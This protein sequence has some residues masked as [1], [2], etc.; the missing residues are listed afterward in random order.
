MGVNPKVDFVE[1]SN[2][3]R[4]PPKIQGIR[5]IVDTSKMSGNNLKFYF[6]SSN[7]INQVIFFY[8]MCTRSIHIAY[9]VSLHFYVKFAQVIKLMIKKSW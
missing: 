9:N 3:E 1:D 8:K 5:V 7:T 2:N 6:P 4:V